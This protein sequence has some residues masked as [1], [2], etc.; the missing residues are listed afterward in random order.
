MCCHTIWLIFNQTMNSR[1]EVLQVPWGWRGGEVYTCTRQGE[2]ECS[3]TPAGQERQNGPSHL[4]QR[5]ELHQPGPHGN[6]R[7]ACAPATLSLCCV[8]Q[9]ETAG[10]VPYT[11]ALWSA[12]R[13]QGRG[14]CT[15]A[16]LRMP[17][18]LRAVSQAC[19]QCR[20]LV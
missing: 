4:L 5:G 13:E 12:C 11:C 16:G 19:A 18:G 15:A 10:G 1:Q 14:C 3:P 2:W 20:L 7:D 9:P 6:P 8:P 17:P